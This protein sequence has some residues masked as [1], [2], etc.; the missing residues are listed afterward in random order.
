[1]TLLLIALLTDDPAYLL[2]AAKLHYALKP[3]RIAFLSQVA[4]KQS[5]QAKRDT[6]FEISRIKS[7]SLILFPVFESPL[8]IDQIAKLPHDLV[9]VRGVPGDTLL[10]ARI[11]TL[12]GPAI[13]LLEVPSTRG[14]ADGNGF[15]VSQGP[16][17]VSDT[18]DYLGT[19]YF[20]LS[21]F[22]PETLRPYL[23]KK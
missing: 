20:Y 19:S 10:L 15:N 2:N 7:D 12:R 11:S 5:G 3:D 4:A 23:K 6:L 22:D 17:R 21:P 8:K 9:N 14:A 18:K 16:Y 1:M 13:V